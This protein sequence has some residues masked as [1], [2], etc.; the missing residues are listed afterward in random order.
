MRVMDGEDNVVGGDEAIH[1]VVEPEEGE[2]RKP[3]LTRCCVRKK[4]SLRR[5]P[6]PIIVLECLRVGR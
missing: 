1:L 3:A 4:E 6:N 2:V 5:K